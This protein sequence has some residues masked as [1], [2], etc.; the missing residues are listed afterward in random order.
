MIK[1]IEIFCVFGV[2]L[3]G[4]KKNCYIVGFTFHKFIYAY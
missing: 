4:I 1:K 2:F 3:I